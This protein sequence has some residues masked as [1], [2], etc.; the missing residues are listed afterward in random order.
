MNFKNL[1]AL[2]RIR[3]LK[4]E[5]NVDFHLQAGYLSITDAH[6]WRVLNAIK[7]FWSDTQV[8]RT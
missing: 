4:K 3:G 1:Q 5:G 6:T 7:E 2:K 8:Q